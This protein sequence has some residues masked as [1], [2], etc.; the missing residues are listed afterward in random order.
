MWLLYYDFE[1][2]AASLN[3][4]LLNEKRFHFETFSNKKLITME[5]IM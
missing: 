4:K 5:E 1:T 3:Y 2:F